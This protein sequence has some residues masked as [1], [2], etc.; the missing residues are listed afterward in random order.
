VPDSVPVP[1]PLST[2]V[3]PLG[4]LPVSDRA[5]VGV[6]VEVTVKVPAE[7]AVKVA[8]A[9]DVMAGGASTVRVKDWEASGL[10]PLAAPRVIG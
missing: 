5:S 7:P 10:T 1:S 3:T 8:L 6:P 9:A 4:R 2:K